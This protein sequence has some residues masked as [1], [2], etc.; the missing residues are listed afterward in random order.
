MEMIVHES[1][2]SDKPSAI[3]AARPSTIDYTGDCP[4]AAMKREFLARGSDSH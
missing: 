1:A 2:H 3:V 4:R